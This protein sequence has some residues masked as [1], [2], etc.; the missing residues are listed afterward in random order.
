MGVG[1][2]NNSTSCTALLQLNVLK[3]DG[4]HPS[5][6]EPYPAWPA[7]I[8]GCCLANILE[9][10]SVFRQGCFPLF[11]HLPNPSYTSWELPREEEDWAGGFKEVGARWYL[12]QYYLLGGVIQFLH[13]RNPDWQFLRDVCNLVGLLQFAGYITFAGDSIFKAFLSL[14][15]IWQKENDGNPSLSG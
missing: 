8:P 3:E 4:R 6:A 5:P 13:F 10:V 11:P 2:P 1:P 14:W 7:K 15:A 9:I 12:L